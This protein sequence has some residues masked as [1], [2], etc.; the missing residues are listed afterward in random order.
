MRVDHEFDVWS[1]ASPG[2]LH[3]AYTLGDGETIAAHHTHLHRCKAFGGITCQF[4]FGL[5]AWGPAAA[6][7]ASDHPARS[8]EGL[9]ERHAPRLRSHIPDGNVNAGDGFHD[10]P[11]PAADLGLGH[12]ELQGWRGSGAVVHLFVEALGE[13][14]VLTHDIRRQ[15]VLD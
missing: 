11:T 5:V 4:S 7:I 15:L 1:Q 14:R 13:H 6:G 12:P 2:R 9:V 10:Y 3:P 8:P